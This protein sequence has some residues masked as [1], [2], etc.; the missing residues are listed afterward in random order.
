MKSE[1]SPSVPDAP[2]RDHRGGGGGISRRQ[3]LRSAASAPL[4]A[5]IPAGTVLANASA[6]QCAVN[7]KTQSDATAIL[8]PRTSPDAWVRRAVPLRVFRRLGVTK[9]GYLVNGIWYDNQGVAFT[10]QPDLSV[11]CSQTTDWC[12]IIGPTTTYVLEVYNMDS[13]TNPTTLY[14]IGA[15]SQ[16]NTVGNAAVWPTGGSST[17]GN[18][19]LTVSCMCSL[20]PGLGGLDPNSPQFYCQ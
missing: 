11:T 13:P 20:N 14:S 10:P 1:T 7:S 15:W 9:T 3:L 6:F 17:A 8:G 4:L 5:T 19:A 2:A 18:F 16:Q 12:S